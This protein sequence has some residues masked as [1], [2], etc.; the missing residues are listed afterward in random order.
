MVSPSP[1]MGRNAAFHFKKALAFTVLILLPGMPESQ[2]LQAARQSCNAAFN[3][4]CSRINA[5]KLATDLAESSSVD[6]F[7]EVTNGIHNMNTGFYP[8]VINRDTTVC[9]AHGGNQSLVNLTLAQIFD[10]VGLEFSNAFDFHNRSMRAADKGG[11]WVR[12]LWNDDGAPKSKIAY[13]TNMTKQ[14]YL[15]V[16]YI[17]DQLPTSLPC[18]ASY[19]GFCSLVNA[20]SLLGKAVSS[21]F[22]DSV[23]GFERALYD[24]SFSPAYKIQDFY[25]FMNKY[26]NG[27]IMAHGVDHSNYGRPLADVYSEKGLGTWFEGQELHVAFKTAAEGAGLVKYKWRNHPDEAKYDKIALLVKVQFGGE[28][29]YVGVGFKHEMSPVSS[30]Y[31]PCESTSSSP[32]SFA[33]TLALSS[34]VLAFALSS[35]EEPDKVFANISTNKDFQRSGDYYPFVYTFDG[36]CVAHRNTSFVNLTLEEVLKEVLGG[37]SSVYVDADALN[38]E[39]REKALNGGGWVLYTWPNLNEYKLSYISQLT[40]DNQFYYVGVGFTYKQPPV[41]RFLPEPHSKKNGDRIHCPANYERNCSRTNVE[42]IVGIGLA[43]LSV[44]WTGILA[45][46]SSGSETYRVNNDF[47]IKVFSFDNNQCIEDLS[48]CCIADGKQTDKN[49]TWQQI[50]DRYG[51]TSIKGAELHRKI[52]DVANKGGGWMEYIWSRESGE[53]LLKRALVFKLQNQGNDYYVVSEY[54][55]ST[56]PSTCE[57][58][59]EGTECLRPDQ[60]FCELTLIGVQSTDSYLKK[61]LLPIIAVL[62]V[63]SAGL[64]GYHKYQ[65]KQK[66]K[67]LQRM[68]EQMEKSMQGMVIVIEDLP[69][70][71]AQEYAQMSQADQ[72]GDSSTQRVVV[73]WFWEEDAH[74]LS[75]HEASALLDGTHFVGYPRNISDTLEEAFENFNAGRGSVECAINPTTG[76]YQ[77]DFKTMKQ[78]NAVTGYCRNVRREKVSIDWQVDE[79]ASLPPLPAD[80]DFFTKDGEAMLSP[81]KGQIIQVS[82]IHQEGLWMFG[83]ILYDPIMD[84]QSQSGITQAT[85]TAWRNRRTSGWFPQIVSKPADVQ[86]MRKL[87]TNLG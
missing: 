20:Q 49:H 10:L 37:S 71:S 67:E 3:A 23:E 50:L 56:L 86:A 2:S 58:C 53:A 42:S 7:A 19:D 80:I 77:V 63:F 15:V 35:N 38:A 66:D 41:Q 57:N 4:P 47:H 59:A 75:K 55:A 60:E 62:V 85:A 54:I 33:T 30:F 13:V 8:F 83:T 28:T 36:Y 61:I 43:D 70:R 78:K 87:V 24:L 6:F 79:A 32:C 21:L 64:W 34:H 11:G 46:I 48:G 27:Q 72:A 12:Y 52:L 51:I 76:C 73:D 81:M 14:Y 1:E 29:Y 44:Q 69:I 84:E 26:E 74:N 5:E 40:L 82:K 22:Q 65:S 25:I 16:G 39:F 68:A 18:D 45:K 17:D 9:V 31:Y